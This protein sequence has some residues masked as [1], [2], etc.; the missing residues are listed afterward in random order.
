MTGDSWAVQ[1]HRYGEPDVLVRE[2]VPAQH[3]ADDEVRIRVSAVGV[4]RIDLVFRTGIVRIHGVGFPK[5]TGF[6]VVGVVDEVGA[7]ISDTAA[8]AVVWGCLGLEPTQRRGTLAE[9][10]TLTREQYAVLPA[11]AVDPALAAL[12]LAA[13]TALK[14]LRDSLRV[15]PGDRVLVVGAGG[16]VGTA[17]IQIARVLGAVPIAVSGPG[18]VKACLDL[19]AEEAYDYEQTRPGGI[20]G[21]F[22][23]VLDAA[24]VDTPAY[25]S[26]L[27]PGGR[28]VTTVGD[29]W[30]R[31][32]PGAITR[33]P[34]IRMLSAGPSRRDLG[35]LAAQVG[36]G[37]L[38]PIVDHVYPVS[39][40]RQAH[41]DAAN[42]H[43][44]GR[45][46]V[47]VD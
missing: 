30:L 25:R 43:A 9:F 29:A 42:P 20:P 33:Q 34:R 28:I 40:V 4:N 31:M 12:P 37:R 17:A 7:G 3:A 41:R 8:G 47:V 5:G 21:C 44:S 22:A 45:R 14:C 18:N 32:L 38:R 26:V 23:A 13:L 35:W 6:D 19:G 24:G 2:A 15:L 16:G 46:I 11:P 36:E 1:F 39:E 27:D 10:V